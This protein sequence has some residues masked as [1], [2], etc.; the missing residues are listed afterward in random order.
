M[1]FHAAAY[2]H[3]PMMEIY[4][5]EAVNNNIF[6]TKNLLEMSLAAGVKRF[7]L[8]STDK[9]VRPTN[10]MGASKR[11]AE[12][13]LQLKYKE[14]LTTG[15]RDMIKQIKIMAVRFG[16]VIGSAGSV[17]PLFKK[18]IEHGGPVTVTHPEIIRYFMTINEAVQLVLQ[19]GAIGE[20][21]DIYIL[22]MG[23]PVKIVDMARDLIRLSGYRPDEDIQIKFIGLRPGE[24]LYEEL[25]T[26]DEGIVTTPH[27]KIMAL[28]SNGL[29]GL[30]YSDLEK[31]INE[32]ILLADQHDHKGIRDKLKEI[33]PEYT[34]QYEIDSEY[35]KKNIKF[36][37][38]K[39]VEIGKPLKVK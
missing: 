13:I 6:G 24:K 4:A 37:I 28:R 27:D 5:C 17:I 29:G 35:R 39:I 8:I 20:G 32:L 14:I 34:P 16:N 22:E 11:V 1:V 21:G 26:E 3:V 12:I 7:V 33:V 9:A 10:I 31:K 23:E 19:T 25:I 15:G 30:S 18:Q 2:K 36:N 38:E